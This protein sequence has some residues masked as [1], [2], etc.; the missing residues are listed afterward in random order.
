MHNNR[1]YNFG[2]GPATLPTSVLEEVKEELLDWKG[3][4]LSVLE[5]SHRTDEYQE[6]ALEA[7]QDFRDLLSIPSTYAVLFT[8]GGATLQNSAVP[9]NLTSPDG[10]VSYV[11][12]GYWADLSIQEAKKY[13]NVK[14]SLIHI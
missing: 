9:L 8:H 4:G 1:K 10:E 14:L 3:R 5:I 6:I 7:E 2:A 12:S 11:N 13:T